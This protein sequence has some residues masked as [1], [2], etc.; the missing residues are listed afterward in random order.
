[1]LAGTPAFPLLSP[2]DTLRAALMHSLVAAHRPEL[3]D[4]VASADL[5]LDFPGLWLRPHDSGLNAIWLEPRLFSAAA[6]SG[7][8]LAWIRVLSGNWRGREA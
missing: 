5:D 2:S 4:L 8:P 6:E 3:A 7:L 1:M